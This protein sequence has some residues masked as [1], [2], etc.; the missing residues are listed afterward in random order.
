MATAEFRI[1]RATLVG[2]VKTPMTPPIVAHNVTIANGTVDDLEVHTT[3][4]NNTEYLIV[5]AGFERTIQVNR[6]RFLF[7][8]VAFWLKSAGGGLVVIVWF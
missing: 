6:A 5:A 2:G 7:E 1:T 4:A 8:N 3:D